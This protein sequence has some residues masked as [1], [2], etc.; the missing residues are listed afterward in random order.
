MQ[1]LSLTGDCG[2]GGYWWFY[3]GYWLILTCVCWPW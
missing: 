1:I 2:V 3:S